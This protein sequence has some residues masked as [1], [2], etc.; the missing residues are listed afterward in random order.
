V[1]VAV[2]VEVAVEVEAP[3]LQ[4]LVRPGC[5]CYYTPEWAIRR[6]ELL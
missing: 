5:Y 6:K 2:A 4:Q 1:A 3:G